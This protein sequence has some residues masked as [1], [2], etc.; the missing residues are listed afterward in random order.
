MTICTRT[1]LIVIFTSAFVCHLHHV[2]AFLNV[3]SSPPLAFRLPT[4]T[5]ITITTT[6]S[7]LS[8]SSTNHRKQGIHFESSKRIHPSTSNVESSTTLFGMWSNDSDL[9]GAD[10]YKACIP[11]LLPLLDGEVF[12]RYIYE[13]IPPLGFL[14]GLFIGPLYS[15]YSHVPFLGLILFIALTLGTRGNTNMPRGLRFNAQQ[16]AMI[17]FFLVFPELIGSAFEGADMP[18]TLV[19]P[20]MNFV[21]YSYMSMVLYSIYCNIRGTKPDQIPWVS[22]YAELLVGPF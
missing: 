4:T 1:K 22:S 13:R 3:R 15:V 14:D 5:T 10:R 16:A 2:N 9:N 8:G 11:Y 12:G 19:E 17:D 18:R 20:C 21:W 7:L 6:Q